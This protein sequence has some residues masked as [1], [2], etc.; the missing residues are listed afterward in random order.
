MF[1]ASLGYVVE[2]Q[3]SLSYLAL[4]QKNAK[5]HGWGYSSWVALA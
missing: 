3:A 5:G 4:S 2:W 1:E